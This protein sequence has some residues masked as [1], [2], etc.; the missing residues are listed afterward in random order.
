[1]VPVPDP[2]APVFRV[3]EVDPLRCIGCRLCVAR[4][5]DGA[6]LEGCPWDAIEMVDT[7]DLEAALGELPW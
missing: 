3:I 2:R 1:M 6:L 5:P 7:R 4:G